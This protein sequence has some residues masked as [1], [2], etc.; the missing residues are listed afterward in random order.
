MRKGQGQNFGENFNIKEG[1]EE[2]WEERGQEI[3]EPKEQSKK[4]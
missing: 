1:K 2:C 4:K 3:S